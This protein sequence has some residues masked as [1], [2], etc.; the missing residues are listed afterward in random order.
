MP[1]GSYSDD[2][3]RDA[4]GTL[5]RVKQEAV[6]EA[7]QQVTQAYTQHQGQQQFWNG[8][9]GQHKDINPQDHDVVQ[10][11][12]NAN[13][14]D[15]ADIPVAEASEKLAGLVR[16]RIERLG[17]GPEPSGQFPQDGEPFGQPNRRP[18]INQETGFPEGSMGDVLKQRKQARREAGLQFRR[19]PQ[20]E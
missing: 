20:A 8:F 10:A 17:N 5:K 3:Y 1:E 7:V 16:D 6:Q 9:Y 13:M 11:V 15:L 14:K 2:L 18:R 12:L 19:R 4:D